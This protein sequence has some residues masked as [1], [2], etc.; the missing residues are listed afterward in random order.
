[1]LSRERTHVTLKLT[2]YDIGLRQKKKFNNLNAV[3]YFITFYLK[4]PNLEREF[5][6]SGGD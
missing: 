4:Q 1:M 2:F 5:I 6:N 3:L